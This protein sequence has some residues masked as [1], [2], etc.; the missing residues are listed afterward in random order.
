VQQ[1]Q[2]DANDGTTG[3]HATA[4]S[5]CLRR[6]HRDACDNTIGMH[7]TTP[8]GCM[9]QHHQEDWFAV[10]VTTTINLALTKRKVNELILTQFPI[11]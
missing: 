6:H 4:P 10:A 7:A 11:I 3:M 5:G 2:R 1:H 8:S 9:R